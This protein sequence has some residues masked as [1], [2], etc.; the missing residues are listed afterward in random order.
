MLAILFLEAVHWMQRRG[1]L[2]STLSERPLLIRWALYYGCIATILI[3][4]EFGGQAFV[5]FQ[6]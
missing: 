6:F 3:F 2:I 5:Y 4:G 1:N